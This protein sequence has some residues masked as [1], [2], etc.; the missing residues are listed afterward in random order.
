MGL[1][2]LLSKEAFAAD[3]PFFAT[4]LN[5][6]AGFCMI[7]N[8]FNDMLHA[9][10]SPKDIQGPALKE[11]I[12]NVS[13]EAYG[14]VYKFDV[15]QDTSAGG[16]LCYLDRSNDGFVWVPF[17]LR[18]AVGELDGKIEMYPDF[19]DGPVWATG[20]HGLLP[21]IELR[22]CD[23]GWMFI[24]N[25]S[26]PDD[27]G[28]CVECPGGMYSPSYNSRSCE[29]CLGG[30]FSGARSFGC[31]VCPEGWFALANQTECTQCFTGTVAA[32][33]GSS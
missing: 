26:D 33:S 13:I 10:Q 30:Y 29:T 4:N 27:L 15:N 19:P 5:V 25:Q 17:A 14:G 18:T 12:L 16:D 1:L 11:A 3:P 9:G 24:Q 28:S 6:A 8:A 32:S 20:T 7:F 2:K 31:G 21:P 22:G 23:P